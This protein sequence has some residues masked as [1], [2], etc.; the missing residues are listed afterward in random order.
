MV[1]IDLSKA[2]DSLCHSTLIDKLKKLVK[3]ALS[4]AEA[5]ELYL[6]N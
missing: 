4:S 1:S 2:F 3:K 6:E 5:F